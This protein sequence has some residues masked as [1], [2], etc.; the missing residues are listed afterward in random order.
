MDNGC[1]AGVGVL[2]RSIV[3]FHPILAQ[4]F[5]SAYAPRFKRQQAFLLIIR[6]Q[7]IRRLALSSERKYFCNLPRRKIKPLS[8]N[9][10]NSSDDQ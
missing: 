7:K 8:A 6:V 2:Q 10:W 1:D 5:R 9:A 3:L 4:G